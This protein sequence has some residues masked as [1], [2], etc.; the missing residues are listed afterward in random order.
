MVRNYIK[1]ALRNF[2]KHKGYTF[3]NVTGLSLGIACCLLIFLYVKDEFTYDQ[4]H[5]KEDRIFRITSEISFSGRT[6]MLGGS[7]RPEAQAYLDEIPQIEA[8]VR[9]DKGAAAVQKGDEFIQQ[10]GLIYT[11]EAIFD[12]FDFKFLD[13]GADGSLT[14]LNTV[15]LTRETALKYFGQTDVSGEAL[16]INLARGPE[17]FYVTAVIDEHPSNSS[18]NFEMLMPWALRESQLNSYNLNSWDNVGINSFVLLSDTDDKELVTDLMKQ[19][20]ETKNPAAEG[21]FRLAIVNELQPLGDLHLNTRID[22]GVGNIAPVDPL[23]SYILSAI[24]LVIL[25]VGCINF[26]NLSLARS[27]PRVREIGVRK[28]LGAHKKQLAFQFLSEAML[29]CLA[30]FILGLVLAEMALPVFGELTGKVFYQGVASDP[31]LLLLC[32]F[33]VLVTAILSGF[34]PSFVVSRLNTISSLKGKA[35]IGKNATVARVLLIVQFTI[36]AILIVGTLTMNRQV[37]YM[38]NKDL[39]Y[40][41][42]N[43]IRINSYRSGVKNISQIFKNELAQNPNVLSV[44]AADNY[45]TYIGSTFGETTVATVYNEIDDQYLSTI[46]AELIKGRFLRAVDDIYISGTDTLYNV[47]VNEAF[48]LASGEE[49]VLHKT[50]GR[51]RIAGVIKDFHFNSVEGTIMPLMMQMNDETGTAAFQSLYVKCSEAYMPRVQAELAALWQENSPF[52]PF[53]SKVVKDENAR[54]YADTTRWK[55][56]ITYASLLAILIS[57]MGLFGLAHLATQ[58][59]T[60]EIGIRKVLGASLT[61]IVVLLNTNFSLLVLISVIISTPIAYYGIEQWLQNFA[62]TI[63]ITW[64]LFLIPGLITFTIAFVTVSLQSMKHAT[65]NPVDSLRYE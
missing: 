14:D 26:T 9:L 65:A 19:V 38:I 40:D 49:D 6:T 42:E 22:G 17:T 13:G 35:S 62:Y 34:Y 1:V 21:K 52:Q 59:R 64:T 39:G 18:F 61:Q 43:L 60:K 57:V 10:S 29:M 45:N 36:A 20:R 55:Q 25:I 11:D 3:I 27:L 44:A 12:V 54:R 7:T 4:Y 32:L 37:S 8:I 41:D 46:G 24:A 2:V 16:R 63:D 53:E 56:I 30:A 28:V 51:Y 33:L 50:T 15:V 5:S 23:Y 58:Q 31:M 48:E 47:L